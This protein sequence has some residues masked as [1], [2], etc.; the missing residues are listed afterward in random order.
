MATVIAAILPVASVAVV[1]VCSV[2]LL[3]IRSIYDQLHLVTLVGLLAVPLF[4]A[5]VTGAGG[6]TS[7]SIMVVFIGFVTASAGP[8]L[9][10]AVAW[11]AAQHDGINLGE[12][13]Q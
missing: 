7:S 9:E 11:A 6:W 8:V 4:V 1:A 5:A 12:S 10:M 3:L 2:G 13:P